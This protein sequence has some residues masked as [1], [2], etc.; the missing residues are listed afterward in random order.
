LISLIF[1]LCI[2]ALLFSCLFFLARRNPRPE[3]SSTALVEARQ[4]LTTLQSG[5]LPLELVKRVFAKEDWDYVRAET[6]KSVH[7]L[8]MDERKGIAL[9][10][11]GQVREQIC[12][13]RR[14]HRGAARHCAKL[15][16]RLELQLAMS[17]A[18]L[19]SAC[20]ALQVLV[21][22]GGPYVAPRM[23]GTVANA[24]ARTCQISEQSIGFLN[25]A[26]MGVLAEQHSNAARL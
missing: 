12:S 16:P 21:Y 18:V 17:F 10:W 9:L 5:L 15:S 3:G 2:G 4:A 20:R 19:T 6:P 8:F 26:R 25:A 14:F 1:F 13:L 7:E 11:L 23:V 24:A 22:V